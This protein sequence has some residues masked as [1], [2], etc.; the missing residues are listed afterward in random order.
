M[1]SVHHLLK[2]S[3]CYGNIPF[4]TEHKLDGVAFFIDSAV[5]ILAASSD[6][7]ICLIDSIGG[8]AHLQI[9]AN[10]LVN[11]RRVSLEPSPNSRMVHSKPT[12][13]HHLFQVAVRE[14]VSVILSDAQKNNG[15]LVMT[16]LK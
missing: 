10:S 8:A 5:E 3:F 4:G 15:R 7:G 1:V 14:L 11:L 6:F 16:P 2:E 13:S 12:F 9:W